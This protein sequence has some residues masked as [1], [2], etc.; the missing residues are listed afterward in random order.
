MAPI[1]INWYFVHKLYLL[2]HIHN[3]TTWAKC[4]HLLH[5][6]VCE[7]LCSPKHFIVSDDREQD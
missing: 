5:P 3:M 4:K 7:E 1:E 6:L 2:C